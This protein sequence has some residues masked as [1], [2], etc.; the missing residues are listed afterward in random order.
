MRCWG[1]RP[2]AEGRSTVLTLI[3]RM[4]VL[5]IT[6]N[7][8]ILERQ[9][10]HCK[11]WLST[12]K[13]IQVGVQLAC[14]SLLPFLLFVAVQVVVCFVI[15]VLLYF[16]PLLQTAIQAGLHIIVLGKPLF[17]VDTFQKLQCT[18]TSDNVVSC[19][20]SKQC[21]LLQRLHH[22]RFFRDLYP[23]RFNSQSSP[24]FLCGVTN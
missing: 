24:N 21:W 6:L 7:F 3:S 10:R 11:F 5:R 18:Q 20:V 12:W 4:F 15:V 2:T 13:Y 8:K 17:D 23:E 1:G 19:F 14:Q 9:S 16:P 22:P